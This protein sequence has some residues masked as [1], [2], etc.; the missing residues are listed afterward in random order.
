VRMLG[1]NLVMIS[2]MW[3]VVQIGEDS[4]VPLRVSLLLAKRDN[5]WKIIQFHNSAVPG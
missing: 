3:E 5:I 2:G 1:D 4:G